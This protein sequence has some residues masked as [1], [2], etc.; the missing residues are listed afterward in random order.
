MILIDETYFTGELSLPNITAARGNASGVNMALQTVGESNLG[1]FAD[2]YIVDY[3]VRLFGRKFALK[4]LDEI[5]QPAPL[6]MWLDVKDQL[7]KEFHSY[8]ASPVANYVY[9]MVSRAAVTKTTMSGEKKPKSDFAY[10]VSNSDKLIRAW[11]EMVDMTVPI[12]KWFCEKYDT[13]T[14]YADCE[15]RNVCSITQKINEFGI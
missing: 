14:D 15:G 9:Y 6:Q 8:K 1:V 2:K 4:F 11:N 7:I 3:L 13:Y 5:V 10:N 12:V